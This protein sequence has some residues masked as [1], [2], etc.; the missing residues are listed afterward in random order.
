MRYAVGMSEQVNIQ[1]AK[2][3]LSRLVAKVEGGEEVILA[4]AGKPVVRMI[5]LDPARTRMPGRL[6]GL[7]WIGDDFDD[8]LDDETQAAF[9]GR[10]T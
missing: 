1:Q 9:E 8:P 4:R 2:T 6:V 7:G 10:G 3:Q 5:A